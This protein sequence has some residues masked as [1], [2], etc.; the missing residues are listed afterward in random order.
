MLSDPPTPALPL[1]GGGRRG[2]TLLEMA[3]VLVIIGVVVGSGITMLSGNLQKRQYDETQAKLAAIKKALYDYRT[4]FNRLPCPADVTLKISDTNFG[5][6]AATPGT[7]TGGTPAANFTH[8]TFTGDT[9]SNTTVDDIS[10]T[11]TLAVGMGITG[12]GI[13]SN[14]TITA[15]DGD[16]HTITISAAATTTVNDGTLIFLDNVE[17]MVPT[18]TLRLPDEYA[19]D[20][21]GRRMMYAVSRDM[22]QTNAFTLVTIS[23]AFQRLTIQDGQ[24]SPANITTQADYALVSFGPNGHGAYPRGSGSSNLDVV[25]SRIST[26]STNTGELENCDCDSSAATTTFNGTFV[27]KA[28]TQDSTNVLNAFDDVVVYGTRDTLALPTE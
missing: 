6:E 11:A 18:N 2:F 24:S 3:V 16:G 15:I 4:A 12:S 21:W 14:T 10:S 28:P 7:C 27:Q 17:G 9:H 26:A 20:G 23:N 13:P 5:N 22:T 8:T 25:T 1:K 19:F